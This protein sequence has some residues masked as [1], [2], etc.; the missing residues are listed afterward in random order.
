MQQLAIFGGTFN[1][2]HLGHLLMAEAAIEQFNLAQVIWVPTYQPPYKSST[3]L[4]PFSYRAEMVQRAIASHSQF[5][6]STIERNQPI[7]S[8]AINTLVGLQAIYPDSEWSWIIGLDAFRSL[9]HWHRYQELA[10]QC[11]WLVAPRW[12]VGDGEIGKR[13]DEGERRLE[14]EQHLLQMPRVEI[15]SSLIRERC[16]D[17]QS[18]RYLVPE[19]VRSYILENALY[20]SN[21]AAGELKTIHKFY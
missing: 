18:I 8:Y 21:L 9:P 4:L 16:R 3:D 14:L 1:P 5:S 12:G 7:P 15:S 11:R 20:Q 13:S 10:T 6:L 2:V 19:S 17:R